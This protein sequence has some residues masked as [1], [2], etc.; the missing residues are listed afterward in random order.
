MH[1]IRSGA[2]LRSI[3]APTSRTDLTNLYR[4]TR[5]FGLCRPLRWEFQGGERKAIDRENFTNIMTLPF[6]LIWLVTILLVP[7]QLV[8]KAYSAFF[9]PLPVFLFG[10]AGM[11]VLGW[12]PLMKRE[13]ETPLPRNVQPIRDGL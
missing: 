1:P 3:T 7:M 2:G 13:P 9:W 10:L 8:I 11:N 12:N 5:P 6:A 4:T